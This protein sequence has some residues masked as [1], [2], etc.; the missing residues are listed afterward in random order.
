M[1]VKKKICIGFLI[2]AIPIAVSIYFFN[3][4]TFAKSR[5]KQQFGIDLAGYKVSVSK[6]LEQWSPNGDG[7]YYVEITINRDKK[8]IRTLIFN[9]FKPL[10]VKEEFP[11]TVL[12]F[13]Y[14]GIQ[15]GYYSYGVTDS[16]LRNFKIAIYDLR[17]SKI[18]F[19]Y[20]IM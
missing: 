7:F 15:E 11:E 10:P 6:E 8:I 18:I 3:N 16:D 2:I 17:A 5:L 20:Q 1:N 19:Y 12:P 13:Y 4:K 14:E 9:G